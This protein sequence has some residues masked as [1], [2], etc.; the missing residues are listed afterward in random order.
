MVDILMDVDED[1]ARRMANAKYLEA[2]ISRTRSLLSSN[3]AQE[4]PDLKQ[5]WELRLSRQEQNLRGICR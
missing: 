5:I 3:K 2:A 1:S 4:R